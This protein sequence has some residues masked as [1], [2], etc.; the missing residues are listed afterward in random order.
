MNETADIV[1][2]GAGA[3]GAA[4]AWRLAGAGLKVVCIERGGWVDQRDSPSLT[5]DWELALQTRFH[6]NPNIRRGAADHP[7]DDAGT[8][9]KPS[10][11]NAVGGSTIRWGA[12]FPRLR[13]SDFRVRSLDG[14][15]VDWPVSYWDLEPYYDIND[16]VMGVSGL[17][18]DPAN[19]P[20]RDRDHPPLP[21]DAASARL[22]DAFDR[23][24]WHWWP[25]DSAILSTPGDHGRGACNNCGPCGVGCS[26]HARASTDVT[27]WPDALAGGVTLMADTVVTGIAVEGNAQRIRGVTV[28]DQKGERRAIDCGHLVLAGNGLGTA[29][30]LLSDPALSAALGGDLGRNLM[31]HPT[32]IVTGRFDEDLHSHRGAFACALYS[33]EFTETDRSHGFVRGFQLQALRGQG[34]LTTALGG[35]ADRLPWGPEHHRAFRGGF[36]HTVSLTVTCEDLPERENR[37]DLHPDARDRWDMPVPRMHY[38]LG[39]NT[40]AMM[41]FGIE[42][43]RTAL[44]TAGARQVVV[45]PLARNAGFHLLGTAR[46]GRPGDGSIVNDAGTAHAVPNLSVIDGGVFPT[47]AAVNPTPTIQAFALRSA[48]RLLESLGTQP[49]AAA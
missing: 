38:R 1:I 3:A 15:G 20:R 25:S 48:D 49:R 4:F 5:A 12:H 7:V 36:G 46:M 17:A 33:Q 42:K 21:L 10:F 41:A 14:V 32:A 27:Y 35:Y 30:L 43:A 39:E 44:S 45:T 24:G 6:G 29:R 8:P 11:F 13:P 40:K 28:I 9:I 26:R 31:L 34:P 2:V 19:P 37:I 47:A 18:G 22:A 23:L 16:R